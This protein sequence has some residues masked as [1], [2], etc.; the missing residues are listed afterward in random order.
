MATPVSVTNTSRAA[1]YI[2]GLVVQSGA[3]T[4]VPM[5]TAGNTF[6]YGTGYP[7]TFPWPLT[8]AFTYTNGPNP[9]TVTPMNGG[10]TVSEPK[11][12]TL[13]TLAIAL[14]AFGAAVLVTVIFVAA[15]EGSHNKT[16]PHGGQR[17]RHPA[18]A[19]GG[20]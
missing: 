1:A 11:S 18:A 10:L 16:H 20:G 2:N 6:A 15:V 13:S 4:T 9:I 7:L 19:A 12:G 17:L 3:P 8:Q 14:I 5:Q